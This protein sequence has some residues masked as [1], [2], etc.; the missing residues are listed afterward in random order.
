MPATVRPEEF[1]GYPPH[2]DE[3]AAL[4][5][6]V[7][8]HAQVY[9][10]AWAAILE[11]HQAPFSA[12]DL[13]RDRVLSVLRARAARGGCDFDDGALPMWPI[14]ASQL[15]FEGLHETPFDRGRA[16]P[17]S[18][19]AQAA[20]RAEFEAAVACSAVV[21][22]DIYLG[23]V[24][25]LFTV[26][27]QS[28]FR[29]I[30]DLRRVNYV[31][32]PPP[33]FSMESAFDIP[34]VAGRECAF[35]SKID[36]R[37]AYWQ[38]PVDESLSNL[39]TCV[40][41]VD[42]S[43]ARWRALPFGLAHAPALFQGI[44]SAFVSAWRACG[45]RCLAYLDDILVFADSA[46]E[47]ARAI[48]MIVHDLLSAGWRISPDKAFI[49]PYVRLEMLGVVVHGADHA[50]SLSA[51][52][53]DKIAREAR[54]LLE[55]TAPHLKDIQAF[56]GRCVW[57]A[58]V[59]PL[60]SLFRP[61]LTRVCATAEAHGVAPVLDDAAREELRW[62]RDE[63]GEW[64]GSPRRWFAQGAA[65]RVFRERGLQLGDADFVVTSD[66]SEDGV[67]FRLFHGAAKSVVILSA[68]DALPQDMVGTSST[69]RE[70]YGM[71]RA[72]C[73][74][75]FPPGSHVR[76]VCDSEPAVAIASSDSMG[77]VGTAAVAR[78]LLM[79][80]HERDW[81]VSTEWRPRADMSIED[82]LSRVSATDASRASLHPDAAA[83]VWSHVWGCPPSLD[84]FADAGNHV[85]PRYCTWMPDGASV[86][87]GLSM[88]LSCERRVWAFPPFSLVRP[89][90][91]M[92]LSLP[93]TP[94]LIAV[95][96]DDEIV[97]VALRR[98][99]LLHGP[100]LV[101]MPPDFVRLVNPSRSLLVCVSPSACYSAPQRAHCV[102]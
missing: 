5:D 7:P 98:W 38:V 79:L 33:S 72:L 80:A 77:T 15:G 59:L 36:L 67:G 78:R 102:R 73:C 23:V 22:A 11:Q 6:V 74:A 93:T 100:S 46:A 101:A 30:F 4:A 95:L 69:A 28:K 96:P 3:V 17:V 70:L 97:R 10:R 94:D 71:F 56:L 64:L 82:E 1:A 75:S 37:K 9:Q 19:E 51:R 16:P 31:L 27:Q 43:L 87:E 20:L 62:W 29:L 53:R 32:D 55:A 25:P 60:S 88:D 90:L 12:G 34:V 89:F 2:D 92:L 18:G 63:S 45:V 61:A 91:C 26:Q 24:S 14:T 41:P 49:L 39:L 40:S 68:A 83:D 81:V 13:D 50:F 52:R 84:L 42:G 65:A 86:G 8:E 58:L 21:P 76:L 85:A 44:S 66:A 54:E 35:V 47:H 48:D 99:R 57:A